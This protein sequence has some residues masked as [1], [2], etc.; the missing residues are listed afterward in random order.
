[1]AES[2]AALASLVYRLR[3]RLDSLQMVVDGLAAGAGTHEHPHLA[4]ELEALAQILQGHIE[5]EEER[6]TS[7]C[8]P[9][10]ASLPKEDFQ[11]QLA[12]VGEWVEDHLRIVY[13]A[14]WRD[15]LRDCWHH[16]PEALHELGNLWAEWNR[17]YDRDHP[18]LTGAL[19]WH[20]RW[21]PGVRA[22]LR[23]VMAGCRIGGC[24][25]K[26]GTRP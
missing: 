23:E 2:N 5:A 10:W 19:N 26:P 3:D 9:V 22:R 1:M 11:A 13:A 8:A 18:S 7:Q 16:H 24:T 12:Q 21:A 14:Y 4:K 25:A 20:D 17:I 15:V 6:A